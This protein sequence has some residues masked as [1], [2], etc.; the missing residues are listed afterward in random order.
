M[1]LVKIKLSED[2]RLQQKEINFF[3]LHRLEYQPGTSIPDFCDQYRNLVLAVLRKK[4]DIV[5]WQNNEF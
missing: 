3:S 4:G 2:D 5:I 1:A